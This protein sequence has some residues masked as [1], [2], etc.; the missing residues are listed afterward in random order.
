MGA[1]ILWG[2]S[3]GTK[4]LLRG[5]SLIGV[6]TILVAA[7]AMWR[8]DYRAQQIR[9][10]G[11]ASTAKIMAE[12][13]A[14]SIKDDVIA[15]DYAELE[16]RLK[17][18]MSDD[19]VLSVLVSD[20]DGKV[21]LFIKKGSKSNKVEVDYSRQVI[22]I[23]SQ[24]SEVIIDAGVATQWLRLDAGMPIGWIMLSISGTEVD[25][26]LINLRHQFSIWLLAVCLILV[27]ALAIVSRRTYRLLRLEEK[28]IQSKA[29]AL[30]HV[31]YHDGLT[32][33]PN[34]H[35]LIDRMGQAIS[36]SERNHKKFAVCFGDLDSFKLINDNYGHDAGDHVLKEIGRRLL[37]CVRNHD[38]VS[39]LG[40]DEFVILLT[41]IEE[42]SEC[43]ETLD[44]IILVINK[45][46]TLPNGVDV[47]VT[48]SLGVAIFPDHS[49]LPSI[50]L[51]YADETMYEAKNAGK[52]CWIIR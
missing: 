11:L 8:F 22:K 18:T 46:I 7:L 51:K 43:V 13:T 14:N 9:T 26:A 6:G 32:G 37:Q 2:R 15:H 30:E 47:M 21:L 48:F 23:P 24:S 27:G 33:L 45:P 17:Q 34:R 25:D 31:A 50:L 35:L 3:I 39:R 44:R 5:V 20:E 49:T 4:T 36:Y 29:E 19:R 12:G 16:G 10:I 41:D 42:I 28:M 52:D 38:T 40:G 1:N